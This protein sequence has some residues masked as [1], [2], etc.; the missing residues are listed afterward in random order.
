[1]VGGIISSISIFLSIHIIH[2]KNL[3]KKNRKRV[4]HF[5]SKEYTVN[6]YMQKTQHQARIQFNNIFL[7]FAF[8]PIP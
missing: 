3:E 1:M 7:H 8:I 2:K 5:I 4:H 6:G